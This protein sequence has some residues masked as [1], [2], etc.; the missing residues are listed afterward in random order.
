MQVM[1]LRVSTPWTR[2]H[3]Q[4]A[5]HQPVVVRRTA[6]VSRPRRGSCLARTLSTSRS[7]SCCCSKHRQQLVL[8]ELLGVLEVRPHHVGERFVAVGHH[9]PQI[10]ERDHVPQPQRVPPVD[11]QLQ[12]DLEGGPLPLQGARHGHERLDEGRAERV[13]HLEHGPV[14]LPC[15]E[16]FHDLGPHLRRLLERLFQLG[17]ARTVLRLQ[18]PLWAITGRLRSSSVIVWNR[19]SQWLSTSEKFSCSDPG[20]VLADQVPQVPLPGHEADDRHRAF[21]LAGLDQF[22]QLVPLGLQKANVG[23]VAG[24]PQDEFV[25]EQDQ[26]VVAERLGVGADDRQPHVQIDVGF[27]LALGD[28][29]ERREDVLHQIAHQAAALLAGRGGA[30]EGGVEAGRVPA[31]GEFAPAEPPPPFWPWFSC[32]KNFSSPSTLPVLLGVLEDFVGQVHAGQRGGGVSSITRSTYPPRIADSMLRAPIMWY[33]TSRNFLPST[34]EWLFFLLV[35]NSL[36]SSGMFRTAVLCCSKQVQHRHEVRLARAEAAVQVAR[37]A[38][39]RLHRR[40]HEI[41]GVV[42]ARHQLRRHHV[43][44]E[45]FVRLGDALTQIEDEVA[46]A[47]LVRQVEQLADELLRHRPGLLRRAYS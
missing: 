41:K 25:E 2:A 23:G 26:P 11:E 27:V 31:P 46:L 6:G 19:P 32:P 16:H 37:L 18:N 10:T 43:V 29:L 13:D 4:Q 20:H 14:G 22:G 34:Q 36:A 38:V 28:A 40:A 8:V 7:I 3:K 42:E 30:V 21:G 15:Q 39:D 24:Q 47:D 17:P 5:L 45:G 33:G 44:R 9:V 12:H 35:S 1:F